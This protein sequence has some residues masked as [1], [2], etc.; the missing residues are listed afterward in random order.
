MHLERRRQPK[1]DGL[2]RFALD[3]AD[4]RRGRV[5]AQPLR[6]LAHGRERRDRLKPPTP[7]VEPDDRQVVGN[8]PPA[9]ARDVKRGSRHFIVRREDCGGPVVRIQNALGGIDAVASF[10]C[11]TSPGNSEWMIH[12]LSSPDIEVAGDAAHG[13]WTV[14]VQS[15]RREGGEIDMVVGRYADAFRKI[16]GAWRIASVRFTQLV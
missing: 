2:V 11:E 13:R 14:M 10:M 4:Q 5:A 9:L 12:M 15:K 1:P 7:V 6:I 3:D 8:D 16:D